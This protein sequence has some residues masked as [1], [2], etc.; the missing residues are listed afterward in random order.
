MGDVRRD[1]HPL[2]TF[3]GQHAQRSFVDTHDS[4]RDA[5]LAAGVVEGS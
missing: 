3:D 4:A 1:E 2:L 5:T